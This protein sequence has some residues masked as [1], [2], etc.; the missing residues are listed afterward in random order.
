[1][2]S[3]VIPLFKSGLTN[4]PKHISIAFLNDEDKWIFTYFVD[5]G[6]DLLSDVHGLMRILWKTA[7][8]HEMRIIK[9]AMWG[10]C[11]QLNP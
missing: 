2:L 4:F 3:I 10:S 1:M 5:W 7:M 9:Y 8:C 6:Y 11:L